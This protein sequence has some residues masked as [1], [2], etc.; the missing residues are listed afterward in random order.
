MQGLALLAS[1]LLASAESTKILN[2]FW[3]HLQATFMHIGQVWLSRRPGD[4]AAH[5]QSARIPVMA[6]HDLICP[7]PHL[8]K[9]THGDA[10]SWLSVNLNVEEDL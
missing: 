7:V 10:P 2:S 4:G 5:S 1:A 3:H 6:S 8:A 9:E